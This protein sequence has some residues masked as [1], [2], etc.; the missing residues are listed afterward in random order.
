MILGI[1]ADLCDV[2]RIERLRSRFPLNFDKKILTP[3]EREEMSTRS[4]KDAYTA[5]RFAAKEA[6]YK[7]FNFSDQNML[8]WQDAEILNNG[9]KGAPVVYLNGNC[10]TKLN[11]RLAAGETGVIHLSIA[12]EYPFV[13]AYVILEKIINGKT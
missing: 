13:I 1:G 9:L 11:E 7:A 5:K 10:L 3:Q 6:I 12:D 8:A 4:N 2:R